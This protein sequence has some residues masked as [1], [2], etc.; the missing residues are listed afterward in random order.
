MLDTWPDLPIVI[1]GNGYPTF[2]AH[3]ITAALERNDRVRAINLWG[4]PTAILLRSATA[5]KKPFPALQNMD[6][7][8]D[9]EWTLVLSDSFLGGS[10]PRLQSIR[11]DS[12]PFPGI[13]KLLSS[14]SDLVRLDLW[15]IPD[16]GYISPETMVTS[17]SSLT[18][19]K[20][21]YLGFY[22][23][24]SQLGLESR[25]SSPQTRV[26][27]LNL[28]HSSFQ[29]MIKYLEGLVAH[30]DAPL[31]HSFRIVLFNERS[32]DISEIPQFINRSEN[33]RS[34]NTS[35]AD[36]GFFKDSVGLAFSPQTETADGIT[37]TLGI[38]CRES[39]RPLSSLSHVF[40]SSLPPLATSERLDIRVGGHT[41]QL[42]Q[43][44]YDIR[45]IQ[46]LDLLRQFTAVKNL[47]LSE[48]VA[49]FVAPAL[50]EVAEG[51][52]NNVLP[53]LQNI[54]FEEL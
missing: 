29:G 40:G 20:T 9:N 6:L 31:L 42:P 50:E 52:F 34:L 27:L 36:L 16:S 1:S 47:Y 23:P 44:R 26:F 10:A 25:H 21:L 45:N 7:L 2:G 17:L 53:S 48:E 54:F 39:Y 3:N 32:F 14:T 46:W 30:F 22:S 41:S 13:Q 35:R 18:Q 43:W 12:I 51:S 19:L 49:L 11:L 37:L 15:N 38:S 24:R 5:I 28:T 8:S 33:F 4:D